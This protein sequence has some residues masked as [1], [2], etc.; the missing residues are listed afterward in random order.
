M[1]Y[2][3]SWKRNW[4]SNCNC[5]GKRRCN[6]ILVS[7]TQADVDQLADETNDLGVKSLAL[8]A[9]VSDINSINTAVEKL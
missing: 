7:R 5:F 3:R 6:V 9:D 8:S 2:Y 1:L 4:K